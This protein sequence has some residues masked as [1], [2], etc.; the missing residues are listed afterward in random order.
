MGEL[1]AFVGIFILGIVIGVISSFV[2]ITPEEWSKAEANCATNESIDKFI[3]KPWD[4][5]SIVCKNSARF[6]L[7]DEKK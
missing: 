7:K 2:R 6:T 3:A 1:T 5:N 4:N